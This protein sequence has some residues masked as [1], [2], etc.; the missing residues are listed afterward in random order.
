M[1]RFVTLAAAALCVAG[2]SG[3]QVFDL[4]TCEEA[5]EVMKCQHPN[6]EWVELE[7]GDFQLLQMMQSAGAS[8]EVPDYAAAAQKIAEQRKQ[9]IAAAEA[10]AAEAAAAEAAAA[11]AAAPPA[12]E[13][14]ADLGGN[15]EADLLSF[16]YKIIEIDMRRWMMTRPVNG[17]LKNP[18]LELDRSRNIVVLKVDMKISNFAG[19]DDARFLVTFN[20]GKMVCTEADWEPNCKDAHYD[21]K[22]AAFQH[23]T[24]FGPD[25]DPR[26]QMDPPVT[27]R[28]QGPREPYCQI[29]PINGVRQKVCD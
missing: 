5:G 7:M 29:Y 24:F 16:L 27:Q 15:S 11:A 25:Y 28:Q 17:S 1:K 4:D 20:N 26:F 6:G 12:Q 14:L 9:M 10:E 22:L 8:V 13:T 18:V 19:Q 21:A 3:A 2:V 23:I